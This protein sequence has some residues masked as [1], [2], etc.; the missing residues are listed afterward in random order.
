MARP[1]SSTVPEQSL[2]A[3]L[4]EVGPVAVIV[5]VLWAKLIHIGMRLPSVSWAGAEPLHLVAAMRA[6]PDMFTATLAALLLPVP[7]LM[8]LPRLPRA[9]F[10]LAIS[11]ALTTV[12]VADLIHVRFYADVTSVSALAQTPMLTWVLDS[13]QT[14][15]DPSD[16]VYFADI[17]VGLLALVWYLRWIRP[18]P[19]RDLAGRMRLGLTPMIAALLLVLPT[20]RFVWNDSR[21]LFGYSTIRLEVASAIG[22][23]PYH[24]TD[25]ALGLALRPH[26][27]SAPDLARVRAFLDRKAQ[28]TPPPSELFG[29]AKGKNL[30]VLSAESTQ[31]F[32]IGL[33]ID[34]Q[35]IA[36][37]LTALTRE[38]IYLANNYEPTH[39]GSTADA[40]FSIMQ[41]LYP[42][43]VGVMAARYARNEYRGMPALLAEQ[44]YGTFV[45]V[46]AMPHFWNM[47]QLH[48]R[49]GFQRAYYEQQFQVNERVIAWISDREFFT[50]MRPILM[51][52]HEPF[53]GFMLSSSSHHPYTIPEHLRTLKLGKLE[54]TMLGDYLHAVHY[55]DQE[56]GTF[57]GWMRES[58]LLDRSVLVV[59]GDHQGFLSGEADLPGIL[60]FSEWNEYHHFK[61]V[62]RTPIVIRLPGGA[63]AQE[64]QGASSHLDVAPTVLGLLGVDSSSTVLLGR[65]V[66]R[67]G[68]GLAIFRD[69]SFAD[70]SHYFVNRFGR[71][72]ASRCYEAT[73]AE[74]IDCE[75][76]DEVRQQVRE[77][78]EVSDIIVQ[79]DLIPQLRR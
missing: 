77:R 7:L 11:A 31:A 20:M 69:G 3:W 25:L 70:E 43:P 57:I 68:E 27:V 13:V 24:L 26:D 64:F 35:P 54:G 8:L 2:A 30:I 12:A 65:D 44:G 34:G 74:L 48:P 9:L 29:I 38:S 79:G 21:S 63:A 32:V 28:S 61:V 17:P 59:Y 72:L 5:M 14:L 78:L 16:F 52:Q 49:Y 71:T 50:Q 58:G 6:Y 66:M 1:S 22:L 67:P 51:D 10:T 45:A 39:L 42:L 60:G 55:F 19:A 40:E 33:E 41:S 23:L 46:G 18:L 47:N 4:A 73:T 15:I 76:L 56:L 53:M 37:N 75:P 36:P 62:K